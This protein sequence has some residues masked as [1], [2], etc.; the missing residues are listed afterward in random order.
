MDT[1]IPNIS[2]LYFAFCFFPSFICPL[3]MAKLAGERMGKS[4]S[5]WSTCSKTVTLSYTLLLAYKVGMYFSKT[6]T[7]T[8]TLLGTFKKKL[9]ENFKLVVKFTVSNFLF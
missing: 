2:P 3:R 1:I 8:K 5:I 4:S 6:E 7:K 9:L